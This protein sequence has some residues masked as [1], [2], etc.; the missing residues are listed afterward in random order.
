MAI[1]LLDTDIII[2]VLNGKRDRPNL[3]RSLLAEGHLLAR[4]SISVTEVYAGLRP[5]EAV[6]FQYGCRLLP[7]TRKIFQ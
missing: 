5:G 1:Y 6:A 2:D 7:A 3:L 4:C